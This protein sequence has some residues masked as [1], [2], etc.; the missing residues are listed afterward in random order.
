M[1]QEPVAMFPFLRKYTQIE[2][3]IK[4]ACDKKTALKCDQ[5][6]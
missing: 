4:F 1:H 6:I 2:V 3:G 5:N